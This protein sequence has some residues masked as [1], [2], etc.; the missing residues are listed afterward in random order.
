MVKSPSD[1]I[2]KLKKNNK[3]QEEIQNEQDEIIENFHM[4]WYD[5]LQ[6]SK[7]IISM[8]LVHTKNL[9]NE[10]KEINSIKDN[11]KL[12]NFLKRDIFQQFLKDK[13]FSKS[14]NMNSDKDKLKKIWAKELQDTGKKIGNETNKFS[15][16]IKD[17]KKTL[18]NISKTVGKDYNIRGMTLKQFT[19]NEVYDF[20]F[21]HAVSGDI[22]KQVYNIIKKSKK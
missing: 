16:K 17:G 3:K 20:I 13:T 7:D 6:S 14:K 22:D 11:K 5:N 9:K 8:E 18:E 10:I 19:K 4:N 12:I 1:I 15:K 21:D 2:K